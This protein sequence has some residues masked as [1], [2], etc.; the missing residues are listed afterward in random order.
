MSIGSRAAHG[1]DRGATALTVALVMVVLMG[2]A[3]V[4]IDGGLGF[5]ERRQAQGGVDFAS[6]AALQESVG[7]N[8]AD[9]GAM[10]AEAVVQQNL[11]GRAL[12]WVSCIDPDRDP[13]VY[14]QVATITDCVSF[15]ENFSQSRVKLPLDAIDTTF[16]AIIGFD[17][18]SVVAVAE[19]IQSSL[20]TADVLPWT[21]GSGASVCLFSN[22]APQSVPPCDGPKSGFFGYLDVALFGNSE[23]G[24]PPTCEQGTAK[25]RSAINITRG[26]DHIMVEWEAGDPEVNDHEVCANRS[27][28]VNE[29]VVQPG[30]PTIGAKEGL[31]TGISGSINGESF[32]AGSGR[33][34]PTTA[35]EDTAVVRDK[36]LDNTPL[37]SYL[38]DSS[39]GW[40][41]PPKIAGDVDNFQEMK[42]CLE[43]WNPGVGSIFSAA[44]A[45]HSRFGAVPI[46]TS[47]PTGPGAYLIDHFSPIW[48]E[49]I[50]QNCDANKCE[51][52]F[53]PGETGGS[54][55]C[56]KELELAPTLNCG[57]DEPGKHSDSVEAVTAFQ[58]KLEMLHP[59][60][61]EFFPGSSSVRK[62][63][64]LK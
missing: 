2:I 42:D 40:A 41:P 24:T 62:L 25:T 10:E 37:W 18:L 36:T 27:E 14:T 26:S 29:L 16:G 49:T 47:Y 61:Q 53:S 4:A 59:D 17:E 60:T 11:P 21:A 43:A 32:T 56:P 7:P 34:E 1:R 15:T 23:L 44:L 6:L 31:I 8:P 58:L 33:L 5:N 20:A 22:Q 9:A 51:T 64:L 3:A 45:D 38:A 48:I 57:H 54:S 39:C 52:I 28:D 13:L 50:Y 12:D 19:A 30:S 55:D 46:F 63:N 35:S